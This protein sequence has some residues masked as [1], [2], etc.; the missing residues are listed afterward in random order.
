MA[1][2]ISAAV[3]VLL[4]WTMPLSL[5]SSPTANRVWT[6]LSRPWDDLKQRFKDAFAAIQGTTAVG[7]R[8]FFADNLALGLGNP[9]GDAVLFT[10]QLPS[11]RP[12]S[13]PPL[14]ARTCL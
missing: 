10:V 11:F 9:L 5:S 6:N 2:L 1:V 3:L 7:P 12:G 8:D 4:A 13:A 14:L